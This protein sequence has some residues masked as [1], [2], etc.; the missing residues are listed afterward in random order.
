M[1]TDGGYLSSIREW[2]A[3]LVWWK[4]SVEVT[5]LS[6]SILYIGGR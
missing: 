6:I 2:K 3:R 1:G 4:L 5:T